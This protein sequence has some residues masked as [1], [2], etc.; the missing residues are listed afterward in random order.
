MF[1]A[2]GGQFKPEPGLGFLVQWQHNRFP[3]R[4]ALH[5]LSATDLPLDKDRKECDDTVVQ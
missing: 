1:L 5:I 3:H 2:F 4:T